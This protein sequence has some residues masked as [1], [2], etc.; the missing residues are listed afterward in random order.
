[1]DSLLPPE[2]WTLVLQYLPTPTLG[3]VALCTKSA[4]DLVW[5]MADS[6]VLTPTNVKPICV[7]LARTKA[8]SLRRVRLHECFFPRWMW[9]PKWLGQ[10]TH[11]TWITQERATL[12]TKF[13]CRLV[14]GQDYILLGRQVTWMERLRRRAVE[15]SASHIIASLNTLDPTRLEVLELDNAHGWRID[16]AQICEALLRKCCQA[17]MVRLR[18]F[19]LR[20]WRTANFTNNGPDVHRLAEWR[21]LQFTQ[22]R[23]CMPNL[24]E[25]EVDCHAISDMPTIAIDT[26]PGHL[27]EHNAS[28]NMRWLG[29]VLRRCNSGQLKRVVL[30]GS[31]TPFITISDGWTPE[32]SQAALDDFEAWTGHKSAIFSANDKTCICH[33]IHQAVSGPGHVF[34]SELHELAN[35]SYPSRFELDAM[36]NKP[37]RLAAERARDMLEWY[38]AMT[39]HYNA[40]A[41]LSPRHILGPDQEESLSDNDYVSLWG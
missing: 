35:C 24:C 21:I 17:P 37:P 31:D 30:R 27:T 7:A 10:L 11:F 15:R 2:L 33:S 26:T 4:R 32:C 36:E 28:T 23:L 41:N 12:S 16:M 34:E 22:A 14:G 9:A 25:L 18:R 29:P 39:P 38:D 6:V 13:L 20:C 3:L 1:M 8:P 19:V 40:T 5:S